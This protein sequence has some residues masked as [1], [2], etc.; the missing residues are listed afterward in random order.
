VIG[1][2]RETPPNISS[3]VPTMLV[4]GSEGVGGEAVS[5]TGIGGDMFISGTTVGEGEV[6]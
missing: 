1:S 3:R 6:P 2:S 4:L 5:E